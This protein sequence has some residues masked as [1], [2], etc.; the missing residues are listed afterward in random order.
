MENKSSVNISA[1]QNDAVSDIT[2]IQYQKPVLKSGKYTLSVHQ[3]TGGE[4]DGR[5]AADAFIA[6]K[7]FYVG[8]ERHKLN[9]EILHSMS[10]APTSSGDVS[11]QMPNIVFSDPQFP[12]LRSAGAHQ[13]DTT[14]WLALLM[15]YGDEAIPKLQKETLASFSKTT[16]KA[17]FSSMTELEPM[18]E[19]QDAI[20]YID[21]DVETFNTIAPSAEDL[22]YLTHIKRVNTEEKAFKS[23]YEYHPKKGLTLKTTESHKDFSV[24]V[25]NRLPK[26][27]TACHLFLVSLEA[28]GDLL[29]NSDG[30]S[31][32]NVGTKQVRLVVL[33][34]WEFYCTELKSDIVDSV[35][36]LNRTSKNHKSNPY[37][38]P[39]NLQLPAIQGNDADDKVN[40]AFRYGYV[41]LEYEM[42]G[43]QK[44]VSWQRGPF[45]PYWTPEALK[46][47]FKGADELLYYNKET[48]M[49]DTTYAS[50]WQLGKLMALQNKGFAENLYQWKQK[51][52]ESFIEKE[53]DKVLSTSLAPLSQEEGKLSKKVLQSRLIPAMESFLEQQSKQVVPDQNIRTNRS[54]AIQNKLDQLKSGA[55]ID[56]VE[57]TLDETSIQWLIRLKLLYGVPYRY[58]VPHNDLLPPESIKIFYVDSNFTTA[59][60]DGAF[61]IGRTNDSNL[62]M[63]KTSQEKM[64]KQL[65]NAAINYRKKL[66]N[67][68]EATDYAD[69]TISGFLLNSQIVKDYPGLEIVPIGLSNTT[70]PI[71]RLEHLSEGVLLCICYGEIL[72]LEIKQPSEGLHYGL[73][74][75]FGNYTKTLRNQNLA[76]PK[77]AVG[78]I[79]PNVTI[80]IDTFRGDGRNNVLNVADLSNKIEKA[81]KSNNLE[82]ESDVFTAA[83]FALQM[84]EGAEQVILNQKPL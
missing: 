80:R 36:N 43:G 13:D 44:M 34:N 45:I 77:P 38:T 8:S 48:G 74:G 73:D 52:Q 22:P 46:V 57:D 50:A 41:P 33:K 61:S 25:C 49:F 76:N 71:L 29:P 35:S 7:T 24:V 26:P 54:E 14:P 3:N 72:K 69:N 31:N 16:S 56:Q 1:Q 20:Q 83:D 42:R 81:L 32:F 39:I 18:Q 5:S 6:S 21:V 64:A 82:K 84:T 19:D 53:E 78:Q 40:Q 66:F 59:L 58:L 9:P 28:M 67:S 79:D 60:I 23:E 62:T 2:F 4:K 55:Q 75:S 17:L 68:S 10:P 11:S 70:I 51:R 27:N 47:P 65:N 30:T 12:W 37:S 15:F 63:D